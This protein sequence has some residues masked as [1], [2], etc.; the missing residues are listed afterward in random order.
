MIKSFLCV[1]GLVLGLQTAWGFA[2]L[3]PLPTYPG[4]PATDDD[5]WQIPLLGYD[6][7]YLNLGV[8]GGGVWLGDIGGP[9]NF[10]EEYRR[11]VP[12][13]Y[14]A[15]DASFG[16]VDDGFFGAEGEAAAD[17]AFAIMNGLPSADNIDPSQFP[18]QSQT[19]NYQAM[20]AYLTDLKSVTLHLLVEQ[21]G[22][23]EPERYTWT[24]HERDVGP[25]CPLTTV[26]L[27]VQRNFDPT[28]S[29][30]NQLQYSTYVNNVLYTYFIEENCGPP[31][32]IPWAAIT[33]PRP[34][35]PLAVT[36]TAVAANNEAGEWTEEAIDPNNSNNQ[37]LF[38][39]G[40]LQIGGFYTGLTSDDVGGLRY[41][42]RTNNVN[43]ES[44]ATGSILLS[45]TGGGTGL[46]PQFPLYTSNY[47]AFAAAALTNAPAALSNLFPGLVI[48]SSTL[49][50][51]TVATP[52]VVAYYTNQVGSPLGAPTRLVVKTNGFTTNALA[53]YA[54]TFANLVIITN[55][56]YTNTSAQLVTVTVSTPTGA[57]LGAPLVT[58]TSVKTINLTN[59]PSGTYYISTNPCG[60]DVIVSPQPPGYPIANVVA[61]TNLIY[62][63]SNSL[64]YFTSQSIVTYAT[65]YVIIVQPLICSATIAGGAAGPGYYQGIGQVQFQRVPDLQLDPLSHLFTIP[66]TNTYT[67]FL[68]N[69]NSQ[70]MQQT[71]MRVVTA[72]DI[73]ITTA[74]LAAGPG[75]VPYVGTVN[76]SI[77]KYEIANNLPGLSGPGVIDGQTTLTFN[78]AGAIFYNGPFP[79]TNG[80]TDLVGETTQ[81]P[82]LQWASFDDSTN[83]PILYPNGASIQELENQMV[84]TI[85]PASLPDGTNNAAYSTTQFSATG[86][87]PPYYWAPLGGA[88]PQ[89]GLPA[90]L[91]FTFDGVL[92][93]TPTSGAGVFD[94]PIQLTD[95][96]GQA[97]GSPGRVVTLNYTIT[98]H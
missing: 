6:L 38:W 40:G 75:G 77:P 83:A 67:M 72:P 13:L 36:Y 97:T 50:W 93:G 62:A 82:A 15:Y 7:Q 63:A 39:S 95:S 11:N 69:T 57:P 56:F 4:L 79:D 87:S 27:V 45:S 49:S 80:F 12:V 52:N 48:V 74:D 44:P 64:G 20:G 46:G 81:I 19:F 37:L 18:F 78:R 70:L 26:Y 33:V 5:S 2:L 98:I 23:T 68:L 24:L 55:N 43:Y 30:L 31:P 8:P 91:S 28:P 53:N 90:G 86:G 32:T 9:K 34:Q 41:L 10:G 61:T 3:G 89:N 47:T 85:S 60:P 59:V 92:S 16:G 65:N 1:G 21:L 17:Q 25:K 35:D 73:L 94:F 84:I 88:S 22:L 14:Y 76:R 51:V 58:N 54:Y 42:M 71:F 96:S 66:M 29:P